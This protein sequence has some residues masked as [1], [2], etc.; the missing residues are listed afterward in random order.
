MPRPLIVIAAL[1]AVAAGAW[2]WAGRPDLDR[3]KALAG[4][5]PAPQQA[6][7]TESSRDGKRPGGPSVAVVT[8]DVTSADFPIRRR[9]IGYA[10]P[11]ASVVVKS[12]LDSQLVAQH[13][14]D[15]QMV[16]AGDPLFTL[17]DKE[18]LA[19]V[20]RDEANLARDR[21][22]RDRADADLKRKRDLIASSAGSQQ[23]VDQAVSDSKSAAANVAA[24]EAQ[25]QA[26]QLRLAYAKIVS[27]I[28]G[29]LGTI[30]LSPGN[31]VRANDQGG[32]LVTVTQISPLRVSFTL[33]ER[34]LAILRGGLTAGQPAAVRVIDSRSGKVL[35]T[36]AVSFIENSVDIPS[37]TITVKAIVPNEDSAL[38]PGQYADIDIDL[39]VRRNTTVLP[40]VAVQAG[41]D[42]PYVYVVRP[43]RT[44]ELRKVTVLATDGDRTAVTKGV[45]PGEKVVV[46]GQMRLS[47][48]ARVREG[49]PGVSQAGP[50]SAPSVAGKGARS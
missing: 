26:D 45:E 7:A 27:P 38:W 20:A 6:S 36:G 13:V 8:A 2:V 11:M 14:Q 42:S 16:K 21:A 46:D 47:P 17:D 10:E 40:T 34:D 49:T 25:L 15:G 23:Q 32:G 48:G 24:D 9:S 19:A 37:G 28:S 43:D 18:I 29:R 44:A 39:D 31:L 22:V 4:L 33:P 41:Q 3:M 1:A 30:Q 35:A 5:A 50:E 12:R